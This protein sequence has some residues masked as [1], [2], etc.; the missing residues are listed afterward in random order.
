MPLNEAKLN[1]SNQLTNDKHTLDFPVVIKH[2]YGSRGKGNHKID[3]PEAYKTFVKGKTLSHYV[4]EPFYSGVAEY[5]IHITAHGP[6]YCLRKMLKSDVPKEKRWVRNDSTCVWITE[7]AQNRDANNNFISFK[8]QDNPKF[9]RPNNWNEIIKECKKAL[10]AIGGDV[11]AVD[12][13]AQSSRDKKG[14]KRE[15][16]DFY[17]L[18]VNSAPSMGDI[19]LEIYKKQLPVILN[20]KYGNFGSN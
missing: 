9:D 6:I 19:T 7:F 14:N 11:L 20:N 1:K 15:K 8:A 2:N 3:T 10:E 16:V 17:I 4:V 12:V 13:K 18:E 5:R